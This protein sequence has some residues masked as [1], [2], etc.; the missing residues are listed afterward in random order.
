MNW[1][2]SLPS[3]WEVGS[4]PSSIC[5]LGYRKH[6]YDPQS[7]LLPACLEAGLPDAFDCNFDG[8]EAAFNNRIIIAMSFP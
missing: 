2:Y 5:T 7:L 4:R 6:Q 1:L 8:F 3:V